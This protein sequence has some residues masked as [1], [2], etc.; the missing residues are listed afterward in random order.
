MLAA[1]E[2]ADGP[3]HR[4]LQKPHKAAS[5]V[6]WSIRMSM[7]TITRADVL[8]MLGEYDNVAFRIALRPGQDGGWTLHTLVVDAIPEPYTRDQADLEGHYNLQKFVHSYRTAVFIADVE[9]SSKVISW[10]DPSRGFSYAA[11]LDRPTSTQSFSASM[12]ELSDVPSVQPVYFRMA[13]GDGFGD[14]FDRM[15]WPHTNYAFTPTPYKSEQY[16]PTRLVGT[17]GSGSRSYTDFKIALT[18]LI[19]GDK[20]WDSAG[21]H[22]VD[23]QVVIRIVRERPYFEAIKQVGERE[24]D[25]TVRGLNMRNAVIQLDAT[26]GLFVEKDVPAP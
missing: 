7:P 25:V 26:G 3:S 19:Y 21:R 5:E 13:H 17:A 12:P 20:D 23:P 8:H 24:V 16:D 4:H 9:E 22:S 11:P 2:C 14:G 15:L 10:F 1:S 18:D 6:N